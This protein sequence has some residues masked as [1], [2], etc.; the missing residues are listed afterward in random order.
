MGGK[1]HAGMQVLALDRKLLELLAIEFH[2]RR[3]L[4]MTATQL[5][6]E[7]LWQRAKRPKFRKV[8]KSEKF[9][10]VVIGGGITGVTAAYLLKKSGKNVCLLERN[11][12]G[13]VDTG[14]T[15]AHL[16]Y[17]TD[18]R[19]SDL[20]AHFGDEGAALT[21]QAG[22]YAIDQIESIIKEL[23]IDCDFHRVNGYL[24]EALNGQKDESESLKKDA[25][26]ARRLGFEAEFMEHVPYFNRPGVRFANQAKFHPLKYLAALATAVHGES[27]KGCPRKCARRILRGFN[28]HRLR[29][30]PA[31]RAAYVWGSATDGVRESPAIFGNGT[32]PSAASPRVLS[33]RLNRRARSSIRQG[34]D[35]RLSAANRR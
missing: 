29:H 24:H 20:A 27:R 11:R 5:K 16:T 6:S 26:T 19:I 1:H 13:Y 34:G 32:P 30:L 18:Q 2:R 15:T 8:T 33:H 25:E 17:V 23:N 3:S 4:T 9:D 7:P 21:W 12:L 31:G 14:L 22:A 35:E 28:L 10:V